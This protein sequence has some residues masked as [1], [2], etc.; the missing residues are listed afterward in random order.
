MV[1]FSKELWYHSQLSSKGLPAQPRAHIEEMSLNGAS[2][3]STSNLR[4]KWISNEDCKSSNSSD[5]I[6]KNS[7]KGVALSP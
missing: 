7:L 6:D 1:T 5:F 2:S 3:L 4:L